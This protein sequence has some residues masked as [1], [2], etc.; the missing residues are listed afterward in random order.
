[1]SLFRE[2]R[3][4]NVLKVAAA[5]LVVAWLIMQVADVMVPALQLP[6]WV[7]TATLYFLLVGFLPAM[8]LA[9]AFEL[10]PEGIRREKDVDRSES[11]TAHT[12]RKL[13]FIII[14]LLAVAVIYLLVDKFVLEEEA[15][16]V[17]DVTVESSENAA[18]SI[19]V[20]PFANMSGDAEN[21]YFSDGISEEILNALAKVR[22]L[23]V[24]GRTSSFAFKGRNEDLRLIG[25]T[26]DVSHILEG[27]VRKAGNT[28]RVTAQLIAVADGYH[29]WS[30]TWDRELT[31]IFAIQD[32]IAG[33]IL[34]ALKTELVAGEIA[35]TTR[36][37]PRVYENYLQARE[38]IISRS[39]PNLEQARVL[40][41]AA[42]AQDETFAPAWAQRGILAVLQSVQQYG[43]IPVE[44]SQAMARRDLDRALA[45]DPELDDALAGIGLWYSNE[46]GPDNT[47][48]AKRYLEQALSINPSLTNAS[49]WLYALLA[50]EY[51]VAE[52][53]AVLENLFARDPLFPPVWA[54][55]ELSYNRL[56]Q[57][58][59]TEQLIERLRPLMGDHPL[60]TMVEGNHL[61]VTGELADALPLIEQAQAQAP[62]NRFIAN[63]MYRARFFL[64]DYESMVA[65][66]NEG[67]WPL[68]LA[69]L[70][71]GRP[72]EATMSSRD[73]LQKS[74]APETLLQ[75][76][77]HSGQ[78]D[79]LME[80][81]GSRWDSLE[82]LER[83]STFG[84]GFGQWTL[85]YVAWACRSLERDD[86]FAD[87]MQRVRAEHDRQI[88]AGIDWP[89][90]WLMDAQYWM[91]AG[92]QD[93]AIE[94]LTKIAD[95][96]WII[97][98]RIARMYPLFK[99][100][101]GDPRFEAIQSRLL[102]H[103][104]GQRAKAGMPPIDPEYRS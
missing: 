35:S 80:L 25:Q 52:S 78:F 37:N 9:W 60:F 12:G 68:N 49:N 98:P 86:C 85:L 3:R 51:R 70:Y 82:Q 56:G 55:L 74:S 94:L 27:S 11:I 77:A 97:A 73:W 88:A 6:D 20:L 41:D 91:L 72:E 31:D 93:R 81:V 103:L 8:V 54:N 4:R 87:A 10:T 24:T 48:Q 7:L 63:A 96:P 76:L 13:D 101:E 69:L 62:E 17:P 18:P 102:D 71:L 92:D 100:L 47:E 42:I 67:I 89:I 23:K 29:L 90:F 15:A 39:G 66:S 95:W 5:Y 61:V 26:L 16:V 50:D 14:G 22:E 53:L 79:V 38:L 58:Q 75:T 84:L 32:E 65:A 1:M 33:A 43:Q 59:R 46:G 34:A 21:E 104:N 44:Q 45:L 57:P 40:L 19:A 28:V 64:A 83:E 2:L 99:P 30:E 36:T